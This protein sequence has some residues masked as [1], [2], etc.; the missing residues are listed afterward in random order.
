[1]PEGQQPPWQ[2]AILLR[3]G[4]LRSGRSG[5][6][7]RILPVETVVESAVP[8][9]HVAIVGA[10]PSGFYAAE[11]LLRSGLPVRVDMIERL[12]GRQS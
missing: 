8:A 3:S 9:I 6:G 5:L 7:L 2:F 1:M 11:A 4:T 10:G 12:I